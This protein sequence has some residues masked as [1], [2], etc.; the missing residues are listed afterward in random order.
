MLT[1]QLVK[2]SRGRIYKSEDIVRALTG[3]GLSHDELGA[4]FFT[5]A[6][7]GGFISITDTKN[8]WACCVSGSPVGIDMEEKGRKARREIAKRFHKDEQE[9]LSVLT[10]TESEWTEEF[11]SIWTRKEA[12]S[13]L[14]GKGYA[15]GFAK[16]SVLDG[17]PEGIPVAS[18]TQ[19]DLIFGIAGDTKARVVPAEYDAP[20]E[21]TALDY[22]GDLLDVRGY[23]EQEL[24]KKLLEKGYCAQ[25]AQDA[26]EKLREYGYVNDEAY[27]RGMAEKGMREGKGS[28]RIMTELK[29]RGIDPELAKEAAA[30]GS[31]SERQRA[32]AEAEKILLKAG[33]LPPLSEEDDESTEASRA[34]RREAFGAR[35]KI[36][37][38][39]SRRLSALG[40]GA[41]VIYSVIEEINR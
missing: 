38:K 14:R 7:A 6:E 21:K 27:A 35:Q 29:K 15:V 2:K 25:E 36:L 28:A 5:D 12:W 19:G 3:R 20:M 11:F 17:C 31:G 34:A 13:K 9:Y 41:S 10:G 22:A 30:S 32:L 24:A 16:F 26:V 37:A 18:F 33:G 23:T 4:P 39:V 40:Y 8:Y 1:I